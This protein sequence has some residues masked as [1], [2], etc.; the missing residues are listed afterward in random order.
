MP[1][2]DEPTTLALIAQKLEVI[3]Q[4][5]A[6]LKREVKDQGD[7]QQEVSVWREKI[8]GRLREGIATMAM[9]NERIKDVR[10]E[11]ANAREGL[12]EKKVLHAYLWGVAIGASLGG[13]GLGAGLMKVLGG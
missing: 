8:E 4:D 5:L 13:V 10:T 12:M 9:L 7:R 2:A 11:A 6:E 3:H 1:P